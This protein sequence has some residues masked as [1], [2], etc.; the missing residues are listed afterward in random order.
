MK[1]Y[2]IK[3]THGKTQET[4]SYQLS[5]LKLERKGVNFLAFFYNQL[6][7]TKHKKYNYCADH[8]EDRH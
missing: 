3:N 4:K 2:F 7:N 5:Y 1:E 6:K 8:G